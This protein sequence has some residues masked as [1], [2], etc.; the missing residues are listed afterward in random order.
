M[1]VPM[2]DM[3]MVDV[4]HQILL[5]HNTVSALIY[6][7]AP[8]SDPCKVVVQSRIVRFCQV[9]AELS[10]R[11]IYTVSPLL[12][13]LVLQHSDLPGDWNYWKSYSLT[14]LLKCDLMMVIMLDGWE[15]SVG[16]QGEIEICKKFNIPIEYIDP[17]AILTD[18]K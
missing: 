16:V 14:L 13:H 1:G 17:K 6:L 18:L 11:G 15:D 12:K 10:R 8:Y 4:R 3:G 7:A 5:E 2:L 9:D